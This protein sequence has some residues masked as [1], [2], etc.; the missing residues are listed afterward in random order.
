MEDSILKGMY[1][2]KF[3]FQFYNLQKLKVFGHFIH[4]L[5]ILKS[6]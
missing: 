6:A 3:N 1:I 4:V 5:F 2:A